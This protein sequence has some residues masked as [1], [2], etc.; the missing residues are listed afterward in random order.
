MGASTNATQ[1]FTGVGGY[2]R[3]K[4]WQLIQ[5]LPP[6]NKVILPIEEA[7][8]ERIELYRTTKDLYYLNYEKYIEQ[9]LRLN[10]IAKDSDHY[11]TQYML[12][13]I[14]ERGQFISYEA[15]IKLEEDYELYHEYTK[16][17]YGGVDWGKMHDSTVFTIVDIE[18]YV[19]DW[20]EWRGDDYSSQIE[21][22][23]EI[24]EKKFIGM[25]HINCDSTGTQDMGVDNLR[26]RLMD[27]GRR[28]QVAGVNFASH[29]DQLYKNL[30]KLMHPILMKDIVVE[31]SFVKF[32]KK[33]PDL[34]KRERFVKQ[35]LDLQKEVKNEK[36]RCNHPEGPQYHD[37]YPDS[38]ALACYVHKTQSVPSNRRFMIG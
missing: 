35:F 20:Y 7:L 34:G 12:Q 24:V 33:Y 27:T 4:F 17:C 29:K 38:L 11:K 16:P 26:K 22:I 2:K 23:A 9:I 14:L 21:E 32:P 10:G 5:S 19:L 18:G 25:K 30:S 13:W 37:D 15:L 28:I 31:P 36:W 3:C 1:V 8:V 6:E